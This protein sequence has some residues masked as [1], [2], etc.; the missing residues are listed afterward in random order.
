MTVHYFPIEIGWV[1]AHKKFT[2]LHIKDCKF[3]VLILSLFWTWNF[4]CMKIVNCGL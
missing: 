2:Y 3:Q 4:I 1:N